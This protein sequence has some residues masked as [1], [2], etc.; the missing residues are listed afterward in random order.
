MY[1][2]VSDDKGASCM[3]QREPTAPPKRTGKHEAF[4]VFLGD[5]SAEG[6]SYGRPDQ[7]A[8]DPKSARDKWTSTHTGKWHTGEFFLIQEE[9]ATLGSD[10]SVPFDTISIMGVDPETNEY[11]SQSFENHGYF[12]LYK[13]KREGNVW[14]LEGATERARI[15]FGDDAKKQTIA[16]EWLKDDKWL[17]LCDRVA[18]KR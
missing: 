11:F 17:P 15:E 18:T 10:V 2:A 6:W 9:R 12:R 7:R 8:N 3:S 4:G 16:W 1:V 13:V 5:W 14:T